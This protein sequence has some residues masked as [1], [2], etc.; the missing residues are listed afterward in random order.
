[1]GQQQKATAFDWDNPTPEMIE[2]AK[3]H[4]LDLQD[5]MVIAELKRLEIEGLSAL[6]P[7]AE[8]QDGASGADGSSGAFDGL[9]LPEVDTSVPVPWTRYFV[10]FF[11]ILVAFRILDSKWQCK[12]QAGKHVCYSLSQNCF[13]VQRQ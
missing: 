5:P 1:M 3:K 12:P 13:R 4:D 7:E 10:L 9:P 6:P 8:L 2:D 11:V